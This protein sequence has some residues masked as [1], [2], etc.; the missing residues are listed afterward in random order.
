[1]IPIAFQSI[2]AAL[3]NLGFV[4]IIKRTYLNA[5]NKGYEI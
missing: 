1:M 2:P 5:N 3:D 4:G